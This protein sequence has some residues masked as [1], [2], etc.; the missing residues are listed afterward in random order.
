MWLV[1]FGAKIQK[2]CAYVLNQWLRHHYLPEA[3][4]Q[5]GMSPF[6][7]TCGSLHKSM[8]RQWLHCLQIT[9][10]RINEIQGSFH[11]AISLNSPTPINFNRFLRSWFTGSEIAVS[12]VKTLQSALTNSNAGWVSFKWDPGRLQEELEKC[13][14]IF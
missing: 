7:V 2:V 4:T 12:K 6:S 8:S 14:P 5:T 1:R 9:S 10:G 11:S 3:Q 13:Y